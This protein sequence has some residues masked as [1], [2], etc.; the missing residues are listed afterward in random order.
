MP[1]VKGQSDLIPNRATGTGNPDPEK[2]RGRPI[3]AAGLVVN[4]AT[5]SALSKYHLIDL[6]AEAIL[7]PLT[8]FGVDA[9]GY[10]TVSIGT[11]TDPDALISVAKVA[12]AVVS[13]ITRLGAQHGKAIWEVLGLAAVPKSGVVSLWA[14]GPANATAAGRMP[15]EIHYR[16]R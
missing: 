7:D 5:D 4:A 2:A 3:V 15:F 6:P 9:W 12:G 13:P 11:E 8:C 10:A 1:V 16:F 14:H